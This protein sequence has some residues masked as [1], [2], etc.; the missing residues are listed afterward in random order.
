LWEGLTF[1]EIAAALEIPPNPRG[2]RYRYALDKM[3]GG[4]VTYEKSM[5]N[6]FAR[7]NTK[8]AKE[9]SGARPVLLCVP[10]VLLRQ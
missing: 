4:C 2:D 8:G 10:C 9:K 6:N 5:K 7:K 3:R 1:E